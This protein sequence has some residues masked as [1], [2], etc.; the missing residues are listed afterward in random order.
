MAEGTGSSLLDR[1]VAR[2]RQ[3][4]DILEK[5]G[6]G[7][8]QSQSAPLDF[9]SALKRPGGRLRSATATS[10]EAGMDV[11]SA[12]KP[13]DANSDYLPLNRAII[14]ESKK[15]SPSMGL[16]RPDYDPITIA[17]TYATLGA[18]CLSVLTDE[19]FFQG[20]IEHLKLARQ[21]GIPVLRK[22]FLI[23]RLQI[24]QSRAIQA[25]SFLLIVRLL[26][27]NTLGDLLSYGRSLNMEP[28]VEVH[29][30]AEL[31]RACDSGARIIGVNHRDLDTLEMDLSLSSRLAPVLRKKN[32]EAVFIA[33]SG[34]ENPETL[35]EMSDYAD[36]FLIGTSL[37]RSPSI[38]EAW[39][40]LFG[41]SSSPSS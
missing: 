21:A 35:K 1:I 12:R 24:E 18:S 41:P 26:D 31:I 9:Y 19:P 2:K 22:D 17:E 7:D 33:E 27:D 23:H 8:W 36:G 30:E 29:S 14:S 34:I 3:E 16:I 20:S 25:D 15:A 11:E 38:E 5:S 10:R 37:M 4:I 6:P 40:H 39:K 13:G 28:L 32:P